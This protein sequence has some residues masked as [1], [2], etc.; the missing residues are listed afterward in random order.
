[1]SERIGRTLL[2]LTL[3][4]ETLAAAA[5]HRPGDLLEHVGGLPHRW[6]RCVFGA[7]RDGGSVVGDQMQGGLAAGAGEDGVRPLSGELFWAP[8]DDRGFDCRALA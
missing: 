3:D 7:F 2:G 8:D 1:M 4:R 5:S 6:W